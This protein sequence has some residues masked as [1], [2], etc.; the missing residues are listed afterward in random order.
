V[1]EA[2]P[3]LRGVQG[4]VAVTMVADMGDWTRCETP[5]DL[6]QLLGLMPSEYSS[7]EPRRQGAIPQAGNPP[8]RQALVEGA[9]A[10]RSPAKVRRHRPLRRA[11]PSTIVQD[12]RWKA[13]HRRCQRSRRLVSRGQHATVVTV[14]MARE[15]VGCMGAMA[16]EVPGTP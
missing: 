16:R 15:L 13:P 1:V 11:Q 8:A 2:L 6:R 5:R 14:A 7:G 12:L 10:S 4:P 9:W 3:A